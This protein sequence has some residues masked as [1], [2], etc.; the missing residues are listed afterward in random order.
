MISV[1]SFL[2]DL[3]GAGKTAA[4]AVILEAK[5]SAPQAAGASALFSGRGLLCGTV[6]GGV[7]EAT[8]EKKARWA[9]RQKQALAFDFKLDEG[10][11]EEEGALCGGEVKV[12]IDP[13]PDRDRAVW[14][15]MGRSQEAR[16]PGLLATHLLQKKNGQTTI[17]RH[18]LAGPTSARLKLSPPFSFF[19]EYIQAALRDGRIR[20]LERPPESLFIEPWTPPPRLI[21]AGAGHIGQAV[22][23]LGG[24][25]DFEVTVIDDRPEYANAK[26]FPE[27]DRIVARD[28]GRAVRETPLG[29]DA[30]L[31]IVTRGHARDADALKAAIKRPAAY[32]GMI[33]SRRKVRLMRRLFLER[34][35]ATPRQ[36]ARV[37]TP[38]GLPIGSQ[39][40]A[41]IAVS[42]AA[43][44]VKVRQEQNR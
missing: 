35:W 16:R 6:G 34:G 25:L 19:G 39:T 42:I 9:L 18:W 36:W 7:L 12:L 40:V 14:L 20:F 13:R 15:R 26:R 27:A 38:I 37:H 8:A 5:G 3:I 44:L 10:P 22:S 11:S 2:R 29:A 4:L 28:I 17:R 41:E 24:M 23:R 1:Y 32:V 21:I 43:E 33:G 31:V 30:Y